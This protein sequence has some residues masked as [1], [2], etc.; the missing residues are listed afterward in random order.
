VL[1]GHAATVDHVAW[2][3]ASELVS[4]SADG[5]V[6]VWDV[7]STALP[8]QAELARRITEATTARIDATN[9]PT[10]PPG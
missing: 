10:T 9:R 5:T 7:P 3:S 4:A 8:S 6:R 2:R 1:R